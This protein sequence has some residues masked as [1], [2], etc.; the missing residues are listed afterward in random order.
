MPAFTTV[1]CKVPSGRTVETDANPLSRAM[2]VRT[3]S[4]DAT[5]H[6]VGVGIMRPWP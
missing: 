2:S 1:D 3:S 6:R 5:A 4:I